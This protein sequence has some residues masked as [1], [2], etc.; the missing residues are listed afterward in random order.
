MTPGLPEAVDA[1]HAVLMRQLNDQRAVMRR[2]GLPDSFVASVL[3]SALA[4]SIGAVLHALVKPEG[5][6]D[7]VRALSA[8]LHVLAMKPSEAVFEAEEEEGRADSCGREGRAAPG[9]RG[10]EGID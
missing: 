10:Q 8:Q 1:A 6:A 5:R 7:V 3:V 2:H 4:N 9:I